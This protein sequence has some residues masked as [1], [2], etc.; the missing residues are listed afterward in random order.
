MKI[1][2]DRKF[3]TLLILLAF[4]TGCASMRNKAH[5]PIFQ[6]K[7]LKTETGMD[8][9][10]TLCLPSSLS[11]E[12]PVPLILALHYGG[13]VTPFYGKDFLDYLVEPALRELGTILAAP[14]CPGRDWNN[15]SSEAAVMSL[16]NQIMKDYRIDNQRIL[17]TGYSMGAIGTW[18]LVSKHPGLFSAAIPVSGIPQK[19]IVLADVN[20]PFYVI[21]S[22]DDEL[23]PI[24]SVK[25]FVRE[26]QSKGLSIRLEVVSGVGHYEYAKFVQALSGAVPWVKKTWKSQMPRRQGSL[27]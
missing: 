2:L 13:Q 18:Y 17:I 3:S 21:H 11:K 24:Q 22:Q 10:Y 16:L 26:S 5:E 14:D 15:P 1:K 27:P 12:K 4:F 9:R 25:N 20:T 19:E 7:I 8:L 23:F 6:E